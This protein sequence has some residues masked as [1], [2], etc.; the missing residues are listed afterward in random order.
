MAISASTQ[1]EIRSGGS[2][3]NGGGYVSGGTDWTQQ[4]AAQ[5]SVTDGVTA[6]TTTITSATAN[7][8]TD[9][10]GNLISVS[11][12][13]GSV[14]QN[15]YEIKSRTNSTTIVVDRSTG[16]TSGTGVT[17]KI[18]GAL[19][20]IGGLGAALVAL[21]TNWVAGLTVHVKSTASLTY[22]T[23]NV[24][25]GKLD[26]S[27]ANLTGKRISINGYASSRLDDGTAPTIDVG[28]QANFT[29][30]K[31]SGAY[32][33]NQHLI[34]NIA[35]L[36][37]GNANVIA[38]DAATSYWGNDQ[39]YKCVATSCT[40]GW[41]G[42]TSVRVRCTATSCTTGFKDGFNTYCEAISGTTGFLLSASSYGL[43]ACCLARSN[44]G[45]GFDIGA[46]YNL[47]FVKNTA[48]ANGG[49]G[50]KSTTYDIGFTVG[51]LA[52]N[53]TGYGFNFASG[54]R[55]MLAFS[56][57][58]Y[59]N[60]AGNYANAFLN[61]I[62]A[63][64]PSGDPF[65]DLAAFDYRPDAT[66]GEGSA[67]RASLGCPSQTN[68]QDIGAVQHSDPSGGVAIVNSRRNTLIGR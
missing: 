48:V 51:N 25:L 42:I 66:P 56:N 4:D 38:F 10:V 5:Y 12:G 41:Q 2:D 37:N 47:I 32:L 9:V 34:R 49:D 13:T 43:H 39:F 20:S 59:S 22:T 28:A 60:T 58:A 45:V 53:N 17:L 11:G 19:A 29:V 36:G 31:T 40:T 57:A 63:V 62:A 14:A 33:N 44:S 3:T 67:L 1:I 15:W 61:A 24:A 26:L 16:L 30:V 54:G 18:G 8:G 21:G 68:N 35:V 46:Q 52:A 65:I 50:F 7:F 64:L 27:V 55:G 23:A 6:G